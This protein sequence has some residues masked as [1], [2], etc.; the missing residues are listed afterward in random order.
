MTRETE[1]QL[2][3]HDGT[4]RIGAMIARAGGVDALDQAGSHLG[5]FKSVKAAAAAINQSR[6]CTCVP[7]TNGGRDNING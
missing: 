2:S 5:T 4:E 3:Y 6:N 1:R 7:D